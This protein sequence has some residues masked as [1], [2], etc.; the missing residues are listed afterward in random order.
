MVKMLVLLVFGGGEGWVQVT[1]VPT[2]GVKDPISHRMS[3]IDSVGEN[4]EIT[5]KRR[6]YFL[7][8]VVIGV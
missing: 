5:L 6:R 8:C 1:L 2:H 4:F 7:P 3:S